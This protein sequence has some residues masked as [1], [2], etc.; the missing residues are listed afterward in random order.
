M[1]VTVTDLDTLRVRLQRA[2]HKVDDMTRALIAERAGTE[3][4]A[5][6]THQREVIPGATLGDA[7][8]D[9]D[10]LEVVEVTGWTVVRRFWA[11]P[12]PIGDGDGN[13]EGTEIVEFA[14]RDAAEAYV[15]AVEADNAQ[16]PCP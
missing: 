3:A 10:H 5:Y 14:T 1:P 12:I 2:I 15:S 9:Y 16:E 6:S 11:V 4:D 13:I 7:L 8:D